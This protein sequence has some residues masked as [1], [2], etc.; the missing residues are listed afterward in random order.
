ML[1]NWALL[2]SFNLIPFALAVLIIYVLSD[3]G[4]HSRWLRLGQVRLE[5]WRGHRGCLYRAGVGARR[6]WQQPRDW[7]G[8]FGVSSGGRSRRRGRCFKPCLCKRRCTTGDPLHVGGCERSVVV[9]LCG[10]RRLCIPADKCRLD[11]LWRSRRI[12]RLRDS[13]LFHCDIYDRTS[14]RIAL[15]LFRRRYICDPWCCCPRSGSDDDPSRR[16]CIGC[17]STHQRHRST[18]S[19]L[20]PS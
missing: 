1:Y 6:A 20:A 8:D 12:L 18:Q 2:R 15:F 16:H 11:Q 17:N 9:T 3:S 13:H 14:P 7:R 19:S 4:R 10:E 5:D